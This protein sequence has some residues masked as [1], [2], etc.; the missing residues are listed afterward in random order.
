[1]IVAKRSKQSVWIFAKVYSGVPG[2]IEHNIRSGNPTMT[3][4]DTYSS[5]VDSYC[6]FQAKAKHGEEHTQNRIL[7]SPGSCRTLIQLSESELIV[8]VDIHQV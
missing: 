2:A 3:R 7:L 5:L 8:K 1:M 6:S 4:S